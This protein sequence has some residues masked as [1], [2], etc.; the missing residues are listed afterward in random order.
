MKCEL[1]QV[2]KLVG[3]FVAKTRGVPEA[4]VTAETKLFQEGFV[5]SFSLV[6]LTVA[7]EQGLGVPL[8]DGTLIPEDFES[9]RAVYDRLLQV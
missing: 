9:P 4:S 6:E 5:D 8:P 1:N 2:V 3:A 7:L